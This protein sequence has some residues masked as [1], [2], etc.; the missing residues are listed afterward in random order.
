MTSKHKENQNNDKNK[1]ENKNKKNEQKSS[2]N[3]ENK[4]N[5]DNRDGKN[6]RGSVE[7]DARGQ[8]QAEIAASSRK[9]VDVAALRHAIEK[10]VRAKVKEEYES[11]VKETLKQMQEKSNVAIETMERQHHESNTKL[12]EKIN[13]L[14][15]QVENQDR[16]FIKITNALDSMGN[17][18]ERLKDENNALN[19]NVESVKTLEKQYLN[20]IEELENELNAKMTLETQIDELETTMTQLRNDK[21]VLSVNCAEEMNR[22]RFFFVFFLLLC[23]L[24]CVVF[25]TNKRTNKRIIKIKNK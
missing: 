1:T 14:Q 19:R 23:D 12:V 22:L 24:L 20:R 5:N 6:R 2:E 11:Y 18:N 8:G 10:E 21:K 7:L 16:E 15:N 13:D 17:E 9:N 25:Q 4:E 3:R